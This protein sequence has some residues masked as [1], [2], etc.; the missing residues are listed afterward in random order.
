MFWIRWIVS[1]I[2]FLF[3]AFIAFFNAV[4]FLRGIRGARASS[5]VPLV[6]GVL[7]AI[8]LSIMPWPAANRWWWLP[9]LLDY[10]CAPLLT[11]IVV[12]ILFRRITKKSARV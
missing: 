4:N 1:S 8:A 7:G 9:L 6:G 12:W 11:F 5:S 3:F 10:G 2:L